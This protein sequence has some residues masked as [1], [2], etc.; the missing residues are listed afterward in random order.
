MSFAPLTINSNSDLS[1]HTTETKAGWVLNKK[2]ISKRSGIFIF[3]FSEMNVVQD[4]HCDELMTRHDKRTDIENPI[5]EQPVQ[6]S[7]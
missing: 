7:T 2:S 5:V 3:S 6:R 1:S 4:E